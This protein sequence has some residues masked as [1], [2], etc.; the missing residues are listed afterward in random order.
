MPR[1]LHHSSCPALILPGGPVQNVAMSACRKSPANRS[2]FGLAVALL[3]VATSAT[4]AELSG[5]ATATTDYVWRGVTQ[6]DD[7]P[8]LQLAA[9]L[10]FA[11][12]F[13]LGLWGSTVDISNGPTRQRDT[14]VNYY[15]GYALPSSQDW[16]I[17]GHVV[18][19]T[20]PGADGSIDYDYVEFAITANYDDRILDDRSSQSVN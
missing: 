11:G 7:D 6:S 14:Q 4:P 19:Y 16:S 13:Y 10:S 17:G 12:G 18:A 1:R 8:A 2:R 9:D 3:F 20:Y 15:L 5:Y